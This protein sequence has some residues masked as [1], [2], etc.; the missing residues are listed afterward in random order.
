MLVAK[1][2]GLFVPRSVVDVIGAEVVC[3][4][5]FGILS[6]DVETGAAVVWTGKINAF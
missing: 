5:S 3:F 6:V 4:S 1:L 2:S